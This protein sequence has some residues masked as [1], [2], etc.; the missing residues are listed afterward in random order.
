MTLVRLELT[1]TPYHKIISH[2]VSRRRL[3]DNYS[4]AL[5]SKHDEIL[6]CLCRNL[7]I[8]VGAQLESSL[9]SALQQPSRLQPLSNPP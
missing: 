1:L 4:G 2:E 9:A 3:D 8:R 7:V 6:C 5:H